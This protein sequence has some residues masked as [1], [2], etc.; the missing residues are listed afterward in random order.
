MDYK[1][2]YEE[3]LNGSV[4]DD[5]TKEELKAISGDEK[6]IQE[7]KVDQLRFKKKHNKNHKMDVNDEELKA[8]E[9]LEKQEKQEG[10]K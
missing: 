10:N 9:K 6:E 2:I 7:Y 5:K 1:A 3:W 8:L 4:F